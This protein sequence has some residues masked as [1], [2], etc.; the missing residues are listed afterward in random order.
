VGQADGADPGAA[1]ARPPAS[2]WFVDG[3]ARL[4]PLTV[5]ARAAGVAILAGT[6]F[7]PHGTIAAE[8]RHLAAGGL[9]P[10]AALGAACWTAREFLGLPDSTTAR[11]RTSWSTT[12]TRSPTCTSLRPSPCAGR[13]AC[14]LRA[15]LT[16]Q[17]P[18]PRTRAATRKV[19]PDLARSLA[20]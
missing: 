2:Q 4:G 13:Q 19:N 11:Q 18:A 17:L 3:Y 12:A 1:A 6:D 16:A 5:A 20:I 15:A 14:Q 10:E 8:V 7:Q 9:P